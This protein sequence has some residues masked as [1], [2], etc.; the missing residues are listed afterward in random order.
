MTTNMHSLP[1]PFQLFNQSPPVSADS[2]GFEGDTGLTGY[3]SNPSLTD[4]PFGQ[5]LR[6]HAV[7]FQHEMAEKR[8]RSSARGR[9]GCKTCRQRQNES[10]I[11]IMTS[12]YG[13]TRDLRRILFNFQVNL[14]RTTTQVLIRA[15]PSVR[16]CSRICPQTFLEIISHL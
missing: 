7:E 10:A 4:T 8:P 14:D 6:E 12:G 9:F 11:G 16:I 3:G 5:G 2:V 13:M 15:G 1:S